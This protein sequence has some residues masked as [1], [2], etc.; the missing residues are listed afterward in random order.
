MRENLQL[1]TPTGMLLL[2]SP[3]TIA[4]LPLSLKMIFTMCCVAYTS[5]PHVTLMAIVCKG[6]TINS[7]I[8]SQ[9]TLAT[10]MDYLLD[11]NAQF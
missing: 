5:P 11:N 7:S 6:K 2:K 1:R 3:T 4:V 9:I 8:Q 10:Y